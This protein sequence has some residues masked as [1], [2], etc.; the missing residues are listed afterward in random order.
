MLKESDETWSVPRQ[1]VP[2][3]FVVMVELSISSLKVTVNEVL[4]ATEVAESAG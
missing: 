2:S 3:E 1:L 4:G